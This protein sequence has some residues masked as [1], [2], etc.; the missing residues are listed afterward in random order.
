MPTLKR[1]YSGI[2][3][4]ET[5]MGAAEEVCKLLQGFSVLKLPWARSIPEAH[6]G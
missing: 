3:A 4:E 6:R 2:E 1:L 5:H